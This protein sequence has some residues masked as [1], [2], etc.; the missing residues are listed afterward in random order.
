VRPIE[1]G[2]L[3][4]VGAQIVIFVISLP[5]FGIENR[6]ASQYAAWAGPI[7]LLLTLLV[8][9][10]GIA[11]LALAG[12]RPA[13]AVWLA[14]IQAA[15]AVITNLF[16]FSHVGGPAPPPGPFVLGLLS[17]LVALVE[18]VLGL[19]W[20]RGRGSTGAAVPPTGA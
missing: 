12:R 3:V 17:I 9:A 5:G 10:F 8:F 7:F 13:T 15:V 1:K 20:L 11:A 18:I 4:A 6:K 19:A 2:L 16:D 14:L